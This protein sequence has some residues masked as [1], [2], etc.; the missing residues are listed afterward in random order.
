MKLRFGDRRLHRGTMPP[1]TPT[2]L[3]PRRSCRR[4]H[5]RKRRTLPRRRFPSNPSLKSRHHQQTLILRQH[6][7][8][9]KWVATRRSVFH[10]MT[11]KTIRHNCL[12]HFQY[13]RHAKSQI[14]LQRFQ[15]CRQSMNILDPNQRRSAVRLT[16]LFSR[17]I[18]LRFRRRQN[19]PFFRTDSLLTFRSGRQ[20][21]HHQIWWRTTL[22]RL[23]WLPIMKV[24]RWI[25]LTS[26]RA[27]TLSTLP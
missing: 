7:A 11:L 8:T 22:R 1:S 3:L 26:K 20:T 9:L 18:N 5:S 19:P 16:T 13:R 27:T 12:Q 21:S 24:L 10:L 2:K 23:M 15:F 4:F 6:K 14:Q 17:F 25:L